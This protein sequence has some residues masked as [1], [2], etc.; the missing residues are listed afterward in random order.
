MTAPTQ[1]LIVNGVDKAFRLHKAWEAKDPG[2]FIASIAP[3][4]R[5]IALGGHTRVDDAFL[6]QF[7]NLK[8]VSSLGVGYDHIDA[9]AAAKRGIIVTHTPEV[10]TE[11]VADTCL[12]LVLNA[13]RQL[14]QSERFLRD[15]QW[16]K[17]NF[18]LSG[19]LRE[20]T[21]GIAGLGRIGKAIAKRLEAF[22]VKIVYY[23]R[24]AQK[25]VPYRHYASLSDMARDVDILVSVLPGG[26]DTFHIINA[27]VLKA[28]GPEGVLINIGRG[29]VVDEQALIAALKNKTI[30]TAGLDVFEDE[31]RVPAELIAM[32]HIVLFPH[33]G[34]ASVHTR[35]AMG[36]L[37]IDNL[38]DFFAGKGPRSPVPE[39]PWQK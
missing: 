12:G 18:P 8:I 4:I 3:E 24:S 32:D 10:L 31:P 9:A 19:T 38:V 39:T 22:G 25:D 2:A 26:N 33:V 16:L 11:E 5:G 36:Q 13:V 29:T 14:P 34:S 27:D 1:P 15:G 30:A 37:V 20:K 23:G 21:A 17:G 6:A 28:L 35:N 7:P